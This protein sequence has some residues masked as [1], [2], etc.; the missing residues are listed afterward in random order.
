MAATVK[1]LT[2][3]QRGF[4][5]EY[6]IDFNASRAAKAAG[7]SAKTSCSIGHEN[8]R[9]PEIQN[10]VKEA[11][12]KR[13]KRVERTADDVLDLLWSAAELDPAEY[14]DVAVG[15]EITMKPFDQIRPE[16][17]RLISRIRQKRK[18]T[19]SADGSKIY[20][21]DDLDI[22]TPSKD[23]MIELLMKH[24][25]LLLDRGE[26]TGKEGAPLGEGWVNM[27]EIIDG[28]RAA[29]KPGTL[30]NEGPKLEDGDLD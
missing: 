14:C 8:L 21:D 12:D 10:A 24:H 27:G 2:E 26:L 1:K 23:K 7:Y 13:A 19:E 4:V 28:I 5:A 22:S 29:Q 6:I 15:G 11:I 20:C 3:K 16:V 18:I 17:R 25:A 9:K 30:W